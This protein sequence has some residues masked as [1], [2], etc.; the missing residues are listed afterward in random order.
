MCHAFLSEKYAFLK[1]HLFDYP[2][3]SKHQA[4]INKEC[5]RPSGPNLTKIKNSISVNTLFLSTMMI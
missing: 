2:S 1:R 5:C 4:S 3:A